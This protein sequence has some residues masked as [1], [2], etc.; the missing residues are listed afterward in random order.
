MRSAMLWK[1]AAGV[2]GALGLMLG[3]AGVA[4]AAAVT[5]TA[6]H[7]PTTSAS[8]NPMPDCHSAEHAGLGLIIN[9]K[10]EHP[11]GDKG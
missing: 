7:A 11:G 4:G 6:A 2:L 1:S 3:G 9:C 5:P 8:D 10:N